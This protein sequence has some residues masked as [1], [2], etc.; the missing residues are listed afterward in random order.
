MSESKLLRVFWV[1]GLMAVASATPASATASLS[2]SID[3]KSLKLEVTGIA[4]HGLGEV[5]T[6]FDG[7]AEVRLR[8]VPDALKSLKLE[9]ASVTQYWL[10]G[11]L[12]KLRLYG[13]TSGSPHGSVEIVI[14]TRRSARDETDYPG[15][16]RLEL[17]AAGSGSGPDPA[18]VRA[19]GKVS[20]SVG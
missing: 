10:D 8:G 9:R 17:T 1:L 16:Y 5:L 11:P 7:T 19:K 3:D 12:F 18:P 15:T 6:S 4:S 13:E 2:C 20:C 14:E